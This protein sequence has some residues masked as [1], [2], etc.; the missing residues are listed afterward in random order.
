MLIRTLLAGDLDRVAAIERQTLSPWSIRFLKDEMLVRNGIQ[1]VAD[2]ELSG[3]IAWC[4]VRK[5]PPESEL[6]KIAVDEKH[7]GQK[8]ASALFSWL[9]NELV[10]CHVNT[11]FI[12]VR[13]QNDAALKI[14][15]K[16]GFLQVGERRGYY[17]N[18]LDNAL[19]FQKNLKL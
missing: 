17:A 8:V 13:S 9:T 15:Q 7:R 4:A 14:Y 19:V 10:S 6:L 16:S 2:T 1:C 3:V 11:L 18:P 12:E 5:T